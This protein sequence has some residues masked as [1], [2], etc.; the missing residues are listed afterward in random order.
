VNFYRAMQNREPEGIAQ[1]VALTF[2]GVRAEK[3]PPKNSRG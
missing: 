1:I 3:W 2:M